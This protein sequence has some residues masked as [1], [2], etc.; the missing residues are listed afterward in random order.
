MKLDI[1]EAAAQFSTLV[2]AVERGETVTVCRDGVPVM[3]CIPAKRMEAFPFG[4]WSA[5]VPERTA[6]GS[7]EGLAAPT[8]EEDLD[9]V[10]L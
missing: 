8:D 9:A 7:L 10:G 5:L 1:Q 3:D 6:P 2:A 4:V